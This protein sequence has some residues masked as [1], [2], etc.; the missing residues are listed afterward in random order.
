MAGGNYSLAERLNDLKAMV[1]ALE[2]KNGVGQ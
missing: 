1:K 2:R